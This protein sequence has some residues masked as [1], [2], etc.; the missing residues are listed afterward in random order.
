MR[1]TPQEI[2][3]LAEKLAV[4]GTSTNQIIGHL[5][6]VDALAVLT[7]TSEIARKAADAAEHAADYEEKMLRLAREAG[8]PED[9]AMIPWLIERGLIGLNWHIN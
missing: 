1:L 4:P 6:Y 7:R 9:V 3:A 5:Y 8:C 2:E